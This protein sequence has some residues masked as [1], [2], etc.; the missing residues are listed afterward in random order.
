MEE[1]PKAEV[2]GR[3]LVV[4]DDLTVRDVVRRYLELAGHR[5][6]LAGDGE[7]ALRMA[8]AHEPDLVVLDLMLPGLDGLEVCRRLR[9][10]SAVPVI[11]LTA[12]GDEEDRVLGLSLGADDYVSKPFSARELAL[13]VSSVLRRVGPRPVTAAG[14]S[15]GSLRLDLT[16]RRVERDGR[17][18]TLTGREFDLLAF[19]ME[20]PGRAYSRA[21]LLA[22]VWGWEFGDQS[23]VT[24]HVR[25]L[26]EK[27]EADPA[28]PVRIATVW[29]VGYRYDPS[30]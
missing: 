20:H 10:H 9:E 8:A 7:Q 17:E 5:V 15:D 13:R 16:A 29:G 27:V 30:G 26:R 22:E 12:R 25:R 4:D 18:L 14:L 24:V 11:M 21:D 1:L 23:T 3:V 2:T 19:L 28:N 6:E